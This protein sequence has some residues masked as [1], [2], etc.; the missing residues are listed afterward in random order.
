MLQDVSLVLV[1]SNPEARPIP[2]GRHLGSMMRT[3]VCLVSSALYK[4]QANLRPGMSVRRKGLMS[5]M[6]S[7]NDG[8]RR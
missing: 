1:R 4:E 8:E 5:D 7:G 6:A 2:K 3:S